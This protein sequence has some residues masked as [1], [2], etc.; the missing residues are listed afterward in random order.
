[1]NLHHKPYPSALTPSREAPRYSLTSEDRILTQGLEW[2]WVSTNAVGHT[3]LPTDKRTPPQT[4][5]HLEFY[6]RLDRG[7]L[8]VQIGFFSPRNAAKRK[9]QDDEVLALLPEGA[10][11]R[12][13]NREAWAQKFLEFERDGR[14]VRTGASIEAAK[15]HMIAEFITEKARNRPDGKRSHTERTIKTETPPCA[16][17]I[18]TWV[19]D[20]EFGGLAALQDD[21]E[22]S[23]NRL[24][25]FHPDEVALLSDTCRGY[26]D[27]RK[28]SKAKIV[29]DVKAAFAAENARR[30]EA[31]LPPFRVPGKEA[32]YAEIAKFGRFE[33]DVARLGLEEAVKRH[34]PVSAGLVVEMPLERVEMDEWT[35][36]VSAFLARIGLYEKL[37]PNLRKDIDKGR[38][39]VTVAI[40]VATRCILAMRLSPTVSAESAVSALEMICI[41]KKQWADA[42]GALSPWHM[43]GTGI[44]IATD[45]GAGFK[46]SVF[47]LAANAIGSEVVRPVAGL[48]HLRAYIERVFG[49]ISTSLMQRLT[50]RTFADIVQRGEYDP[51]ANTVHDA[52]TV[53]FVLVRWVVD[54]YHN[55]PRPELG[56]ETPLQAWQRLEKTHGVP[57]PPGLARRRAAFGTRLERTVTTRGVRV[58]GVDYSNQELQ[59]WYRG[60]GD[61]EVEV[62]WLASDIGAVLVKLGKKFVEVPAVHAAFHGVAAEAWLAAGRDLRARMKRTEEINAD[63]V[64]EALRAIDAVDKAARARV[65]LVVPDWS[66]DRIEREERKLFTG[67]SVA[68]PAMPGEAAQ[69][70]DLLADAVPA[71]G[72]AVPATTAAK[73]CPSRVK[74]AT[75]AGPAAPG[76]GA[77]TGKPGP[78][79]PITPGRLS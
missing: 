79:K 72:K 2:R 20:Y 21:R 42:V 9:R 48:P 26:L 54:I 73:P 40:D 12:V 59:R 38:W 36:D 46:S 33:I 60:N 69:P 51:G 28:P 10:L 74:P 64:H 8:E 23:G 52:E 78:R 30:A 11:K 7:L 68:E 24:S 55:R 75:L 35:T 62:R 44:T 15:P 47:R 31:G 77:T 3:L 41:D 53:A 16:K 76:K 4:F 25:R 58:L 61:R 49:E 14:V 1:M 63:I 13:L 67:F 45:S 22:V 5:T 66:A 65:D 32:V 29:R 56:G 18:L 43:H 37:P 71:G 34:Q 50:G 57:P 6:L 17:S 27:S 39:R 70:G 19:R